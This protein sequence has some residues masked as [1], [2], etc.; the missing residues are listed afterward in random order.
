MQSLVVVFDPPVFDGE[1]NPVAPLPAPVAVISDSGCVTPSAVPS[2]PG[3]KLRLLV[4]RVLT[5]Q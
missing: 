4:K 5:M 3:K 2:V 1:P